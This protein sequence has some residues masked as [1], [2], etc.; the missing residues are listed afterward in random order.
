MQAEGN[1][2]FSPAALIFSEIETHV[3]STA[4]IAAAGGPRRHQ[5]TVETLLTEVR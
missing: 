3:F 5:I 4:F 2:I 1:L